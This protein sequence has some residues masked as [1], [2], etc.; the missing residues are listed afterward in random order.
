MGDWPTAVRHAAEERH[1]G[2]LRGMGLSLPRLLPY[3]QMSWS[4]Q[5][6]G[7]VLQMIGGIQ[8]LRAPCWVQQKAWHLLPGATEATGFEQLMAMASGRRWR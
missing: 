2:Q 4:A 6:R 5:R 3:E 8:W 7:V 1:R